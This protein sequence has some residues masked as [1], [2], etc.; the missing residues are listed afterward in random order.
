MVIKTLFA[1]VSAIFA[2]FILA[3]ANACEP[4]FEMP[5]VQDAI[6][7]SDLIIIGKR[8]AGQ[9]YL[10]NYFNDYQDTPRRI[11]V[12]KVLKAQQILR[13]ALG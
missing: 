2:V 7:Q 5:K 9:E 12:L 11:E 13:V 3:Q 6:E 4:P 1:T 8:A 10:D